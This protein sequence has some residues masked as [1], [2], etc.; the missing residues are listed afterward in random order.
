MRS[1]PAN[2][3]VRPALLAAALTL[4]GWCFLQ[5]SR[6]ESPKERRFALKA[7][8]DKFWTL[9]APD[10]KLTKVGGGFGFTE[11]PVW[12]ARGFLYVSDEEQNKI[13]RLWLDGRKEELIA[14]GDPDGNTYDGKRRLI[15]CASVLRA[16]IAIT[17]DGHYKILADRFE[18][19]RLNSPNDVIIGPDGDIYFTDPT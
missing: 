14:L 12:D 6:A 11:G 4:L 10:A 16:M 3:F 17:S 18:G 5:G 9:V 7:D 1:F 13:Y 15:D 19:K 2:A 8:S